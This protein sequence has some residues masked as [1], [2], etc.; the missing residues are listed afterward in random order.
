MPEIGDQI[1]VCVKRSVLGQKWSEI[2]S[3]QITDFIDAQ[4]V[5]VSLE[6]SGRQEYVIFQDKSLEEIFQNKSCSNCIYRLEKLVT[7]NCPGIYRRREE[8]N[9]MD[10]TSDS[11]TLD[12]N[13]SR[14]PSS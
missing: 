2:R 5:E 9:E 6:I 12:V 11:D 4:T 3:G 14:M 8:E 10:R 13:V 1:T 7:D